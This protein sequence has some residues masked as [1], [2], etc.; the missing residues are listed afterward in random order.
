MNQRT[1]SLFSLQTRYPLSA[2][3]LAHVVVP[4]RIADHLIFIPRDI[5]FR[6]LENQGYIRRALF[7]FSQVEGKQSPRYSADEIRRSSVLAWAR[8]LHLRVER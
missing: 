7:Q 5:G 2:P 6:I 3:D 8:P 4:H 1:G